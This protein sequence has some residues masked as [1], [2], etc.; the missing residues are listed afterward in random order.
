MPFGEEISNIGERTNGSDAVRKQFT[1]YERDNETSLDYAKARMFG[2]SLGRFTSP[3]PLST[4]AKPGIPQS[5]NRYVYVL[6]NP[7]TLTDPTGMV[8]GYYDEDGRRHFH[9]FSGDAGKFGGHA[10]S[11]YTGSRVVDNTNA[12]K[13]RL[14]DGG[15]YKVLKALPASATSAS[16]N[17]PRPQAQNSA[18]SSNGG[19]YVNH[20]LLNSLAEHGSTDEKIMFGAAGA[21]VVLGTGGAACLE[22]CPGVGA[23]TLTTLGLGGATLAPPAANALSQLQGKDLMIFEEA[24]EGG[25][26]A[27]APF[28]D[29]VG[30]LSFAVQK[31]VGMHANVNYLGTVNGSEVYGSAVTRVGIVSIDGVTMVV[32][33]VGDQPQILGPLQ[34]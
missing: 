10:Y 26:N 13:I 7:L 14:L 6:N 28:M 12:G 16:N 25:A 21:A 9:W 22:L 19:G 2:Y 27:S 1:G 15:G 33:M 17:T 23:S 30:Q 3:D 4:S 20:D 24:I 29:N 11:N 18:P 8:W 31:V 5:L 34:K 32:R